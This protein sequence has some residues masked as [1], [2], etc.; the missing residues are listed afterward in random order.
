[1]SEM[2]VDLSERSL[3]EGCIKG[4]RQFQEAL[5]RKYATEMYSICLA[6]ENNRS[7][8]KDILQTAFLKVFRSIDKFRYQGS[9]RSWIRRIITNTAIDFYRKNKNETIVEFK[10]ELY[11]TLEEKLELPEDNYEKIIQEVS[12][13]PSGARIVF[14]LYA[15]EGLTHKEIA[16]ELNISVGTS[17]SQLNRAKKMLREALQIA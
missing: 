8:A 4:D 11:D 7:E 9:L 14:N 10:D 16:D 2:N 15:L 13:L 6:Y 5:Y 1:M 3:I 17:K 12:K